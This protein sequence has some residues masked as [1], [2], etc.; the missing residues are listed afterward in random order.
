VLNW[1]RLV[2]SD[3]YARLR[4]A[5]RF[6]SGSCALRLAPLARTGQ[7]CAAP[8]RFGLLMLL[9]LAACSCDE[10]GVLRPQ[11]PGSCEPTF[12]CPMGFEY[13]LGS[14]K[15]SRCAADTECC[16]G[17]KCN[18][19]AGFC[20]N[21][22]E[23]LECSGDDD[24][25]IAGQKCL[26]I[27]GGRFCGYPNRGN[28]LSSAMTEACASGADCDSDR[29][30]FATRCVTD[31][32]CEGG[33]P[34]GEACE[35][36]TNTCYPAPQMVASCMASCSEG[37]M[38]VIK[39]PD[40]MTGPLC[41]ALECECATL[42]PVRTGQF[43]WYASA[44]I[45]ADEVLVSAYDP[46]YGDLVVAHYT[47]R[48]ERGFVDYVDGY[49]SGGP[50]V[51]NPMGIR[52]GHDEP[53]DDVGK[54]TSIAVDSTGSVHVAYYD[55]DSGALKYANRSGGVWKTTIVDDDGDVGYYT[56]I[57][58]SPDGRPAIAYML[59]DGSLPNDPM[60]HTALKLATARSN[61]PLTPTDWTVDFV[62]DQPRPT[63][64]CGGGCARDQACVDLGMGP[65][66][67]PTAVGCGGCMMGEVCVQT[68]TGTIAECRERISTVPL[69]D[70]IEGTG[71]F[72]SLAFDPS[73]RPVIAYYD[74]IAGDLRLAQGDGAGGYSLRTLD[75][76]DAMTP[77]DVGQHASVAVSP[78]GEIGVAYFD[79]TRDDLVYLDVAT[80]VREIVDNGVTPPDLRLVGADASL[81]FDESGRPAVA[82]QDPTNIDL[83]YARRLSPGT[84]STEQL[85]GGPTP[86]SMT[87]DGKASGFYVDQTRRAADAFISSVDVSF[88]PEGDLLL[89]V[90]I[91]PKR[92]D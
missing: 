47:T 1:S 7:L 14:C 63:Q 52:G 12:T 39:N 34:D 27:R 64:L 78:A 26:D 55:Q 31:A 56:S 54:H 79:A 82:Y 59:V 83:L 25:E 38:L 76:N 4:L 86:G 80:G 5:A 2:R 45:L 29:T 89:D 19:A 28:A 85:R 15:A 61:I 24:C 18:A 68:G 75:G 22:L 81:I 65:A 50:I 16:P 46:G 20:V 13:R 51:G 74:R 32:P 11:L 87:M 23:D 49:P 36:D 30:C 3:G 73:G 58:I 77:T 53:G 72:A 84:W 43:G 70:L 69:D 35:V 37:Q 60:P 6:A 67:E 8:F 17:Q 88:T 33:C 42:P 57:A 91:T 10:E 44:A 41:C 92:L 62:D 90:V 66:C 71:L 40:T 21:R 48:G 9:P